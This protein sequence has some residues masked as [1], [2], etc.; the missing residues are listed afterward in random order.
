MEIVNFTPWQ[1]LVGGMIIALS[2][3]VMLYS[4]GQICGISGIAGSFLNHVK[5]FSWRHSFII[6]L[7]IGGAIS[8]HL[9]GFSHFEEGFIKRWQLILG[10]LIVGFGTRF[11]RGCTSG[12]GVCGIPRG[13]IRS[14]FATMIFMATAFITTYMV[15][16]EVLK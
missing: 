7:I 1:S 2:T 5:N 14:I 12:H 10:G 13:S 4:L 15:H 11:G 3:S 9:L 6:G 16:G 8:I